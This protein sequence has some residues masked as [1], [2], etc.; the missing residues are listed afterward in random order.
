MRG[1]E[2]ADRTD[3]RL[4][5]Q[6]ILSGQYESVQMLICTASPRLPTMTAQQTLQDILHPETEGGADS[7]TLTV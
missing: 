2:I 7:L 6:N 1:V 3:T 4:C 5:K